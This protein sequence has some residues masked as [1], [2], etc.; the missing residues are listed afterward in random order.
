MGFG[1]VESLI[2]TENK[3]VNTNT[4]LNNS[5]MQEIKIAVFDFVID[6]SIV[7]IYVGI[8]FL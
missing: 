4:P 6:I 1:V 5:T 8:K 3:I 2:R 7:L